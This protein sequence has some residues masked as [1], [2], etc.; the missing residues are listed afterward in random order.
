MSLA[1]GTGFAL[2][3]YSYALIDIFP[4]FSKRIMLLTILAG[5]IGAIGYFFLLELWIIPRLN[6]MK[7]NARWAFIGGS[8][9]GGLIVMFGGTNAWTSPARYINFLLPRQT[10]EIS[11]PALQ[12]SAGKDTTLLW[13]TTSA[14]EISYETVSY[15]GWERVDNSLVLIDPENNNLE[16]RGITGGKAILMF[17]QSP[18]SGNIDI[19]WN[20]SHESLD[21]F[22]VK[23]NEYLYVYNFDV[24]WYASRGFVLALTAVNFTFL[25]CALSI[26]VWQKRSIFLDKLKIS[27]VSR[28]SK[29]EW[30]IIFGLVTIT[31]LLRIFNLENLSPYTDEYIHLNA[32]KQVLHGVPLN[33]IYQRGMFIVTLPVSFFFGLFGAEIW[34]ARLP[35]VLFNAL[36][37]VPLY[38]ITRKINRPIAVLSCLLY[39]TNPWTIAISRN[40][41]EYAYYPFYC[42]WTVYGL[43]MFI[44]KFP[45]H[46]ALARDW[47]RLCKLNTFTLGLALLI[48]LIYISIIDKSS[49]FRVIVI[50]Y[51]VFGLFLLGKVNLKDKLNISFLLILGSLVLYGTYTFLEQDLN[52]SLI[53]KFNNGILQYF[54]SNAPQQWFFN[55]IA[56]I[57]ILGLI[58]AVLTSILLK[59]YAFVFPAFTALFFSYFAA[60]Y[61]FYE[62]EMFSAPRHM[63]NLEFWYIPLLGIGCYLIGIFIQ[64]VFIKKIYS[65]LT[66]LV[67]IL[68]SFNF[69][70]VLLPTFYNLNGDMPIT[71][72][73]HDDVGPVHSFLLEHATRDDVLISTVYCSFAQWKE[74]PDFETMYCFNLSQ[75]NPRDYI[76]SVVDQ[77]DSGWIVIDKLRLNWLNALPLETISTGNKTIQYLGAFSDQYLYRW[78]P[79]ASSP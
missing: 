54:F 56:I 14:G 6:G 70:Q 36:A 53:P 27:L 45:D 51:G 47:K 67:L 20:G 55:R 39:A 9:L 71:L 16:W 49:T 72:E 18:L 42:Y 64:V 23:E 52:V 60:F 61:F 21:L 65:Y 15:Q 13:F 37:I 59:R 32:A 40:V 29:S 30:L 62:Y 7:K 12:Q 43:I 41:R 74:E 31:I 50:A 28:S 76:F 33:S 24:P 26:L 46:F 35:G 10:L 73:Y 68:L 75:N 25:F 5:L 8:I 58:G 11:I 78:E 4:A 1:L 44:E 3:L 2:S 22:S 19:A 66:M 57:P 77:Y 38:L 79:I 34:V 69:N 17:R 48:P 63:N